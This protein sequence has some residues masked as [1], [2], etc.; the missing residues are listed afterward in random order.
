MELRLP[1]IRERAKQ[2]A[3][4]LPLDILQRVVKEEPDPT[5]QHIEQISKVKKQAILHK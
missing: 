3:A 2:W 1:M 4:G 5:K